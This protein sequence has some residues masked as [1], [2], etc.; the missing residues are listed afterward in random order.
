MADKTV[1]AIA[2]AEVASVADIEVEA[3]GIA[4]T[5]AAVDNMSVVVCS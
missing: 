4:A 3:V 2:V 5:P 1:A